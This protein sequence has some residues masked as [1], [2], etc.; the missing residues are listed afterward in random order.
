MSTRALTELEWDA[1]TSAIVLQR[2]TWEQ[3]GLED[4]E[5]SAGQAIAALDRASLKCWQLAPASVRRSAAAAVQSTRPRLLSDWLQLL[6]RA[7]DL[8]Y[9]VEL[10]EHCESIDS[11]GLLGA[12][13]GVC[14]YGKRV[15]RLRRELTEADRCFVLRHEL[16][17]AAIGRPG[18]HNR[19]I[20]ERWHREHRAEIDAI[21]ERIYGPAR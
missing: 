1:L 17:H 7:D 3:D 10:V 19:E 6:A 9:S 14:I 8:G 5:T 21:S 13:L 20:D 11:P 2:T 15:I 12:A 16:E 18:P 4:A